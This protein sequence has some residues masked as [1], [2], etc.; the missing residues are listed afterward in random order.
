[1]F[2]SLRKR[3]KPFDSYP[4]YVNKF[5]RQYYHRFLTDLDLLEALTVI[6]GPTMLGG[7]S[8]LTKTGEAFAAIGLK[9]V[10]GEPLDTPQVSFVRKLVLDINLYDVKEVLD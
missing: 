7:K 4:A 5:N 2:S 1:M 6:L 3:T 9:K 10:T 8:S